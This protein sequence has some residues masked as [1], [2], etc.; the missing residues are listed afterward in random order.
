MSTAC[1]HCRARVSSSELLTVIRTLLLQ[2]SP[3]GETV[4]PGIGDPAALGIYPWIL[5]EAL[6][7]LRLTFKSHRD[8]PFRSR[9]EYG[10]IDWQAV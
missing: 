4:H 2:L 6:A 1:P 9:R 3:R 5:E 10:H 8:L 7:K